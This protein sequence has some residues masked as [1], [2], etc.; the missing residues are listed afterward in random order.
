MATL[1]IKLP[2]LPAVSHVLTDEVVTIGRALSNI[3]QVED[4]TVS[5]RHA[6]LTLVD[7]EYHLKDFGSTNGTRI[8]GQAIKEAILH[9]G[10][11]IKFARVEAEFQMSALA[12][13]SSSPTASTSFMTKPAA[14]APAAPRPAGGPAV[15]VVEAGTPPARPAPVAPTI[16][17]PAGPAAPAAP[18][19]PA[20]S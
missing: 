17:R 5:Q 8:N 16:V 14:P 7:G 10:D 6:Q 1:T 13:I 4:E 3:I 2:N 19:P 11:Q 12:A 18:A 15:V 20:P 9:H